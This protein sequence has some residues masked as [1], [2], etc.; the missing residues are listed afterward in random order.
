[1]SDNPKV[2]ISH[3]SED[4][5]RFVLEFATKLRNVGI[6]AWV[7]K[8]EMLPGD[9]L[10]DKIFEEGIKEADSFIVVLSINSIE[11]P[12][13]REE[14]NT[15]I[16]KRISDKTKIIPIVLDNV[17]VPECL[18][19]TLYEPIKDI[20]NYNEAFSRIKNSILGINDKPELGEIPAYVNKP[21]LRISGLN[22]IDNLIIETACKIAIEHDDEKLIATN[23]IYNKLS[24]SGIT[25][26]DFKTSLDFLYRKG[27]LGGIKTM[28]RENPYPFIEL[29]FISLENYILAN[30]DD[31][32]TI[33]KTVAIEI[34]NGCHSSNRIAEKHKI[35][36]VIVNHIVETLSR[37]GMIQFS[38]TASSNCSIYDVSPELNRVLQQ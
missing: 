14:L 8:W 16:V 38:H 37:K 9:S 22:N 4:K 5:K 28:N 25:R 35:S 6:D 34:V 2:F 21:V 26:E 31:Y 7:D 15:A 30:Y 17:E 23:P 33:F 32:E 24:S 27:Y 12:W 10:V 20:N 11:K 3:A 13:V 18:K 1:M 19:S 29:K 36:I